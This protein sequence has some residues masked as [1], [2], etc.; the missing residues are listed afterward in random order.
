MKVLCEG[1]EKNFFYF[2]VFF[3]SPFETQFSFC[4]V[5]FI[6]QDIVSP[7]D[8]AAVQDVQCDSTSNQEICK[9]GNCY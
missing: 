6:F 2:C 8:L 9:I 1:L 7:E 5:V 3:I 4:N